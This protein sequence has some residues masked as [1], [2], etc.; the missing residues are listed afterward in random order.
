[1]SNTTHLSPKNMGAFAFE[2]LTPA[3]S[4]AITTAVHTPTDAATKGKAQRVL[5]TVASGV[6]APGTATDAV[7]YRLDGV[8]PTATVGHYLLHGQSLILD[9]F[10]DITGF[11]VIAAA[12]ASTPTVAVTAFR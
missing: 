10:L 4:T 1:M 9:N 6:A 11:R 8:A 2:T 3:A 5:I 7:R 12:G